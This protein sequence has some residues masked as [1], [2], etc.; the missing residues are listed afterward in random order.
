MSAADRREELEAAIWQR[1]NPA[2]GH[3]AL[4]VILSYADD[5][6]EAVADER[7]TGHVTERATG[8]ERLAEAT[9]EAARRQP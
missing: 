4:T 5:Y 6:A 9:A 2:L 7:I 1:L 3:G 8:R